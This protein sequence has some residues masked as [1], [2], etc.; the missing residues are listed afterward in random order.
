MRDKTEQCNSL[1]RDA[2]LIAIVCSVLRDASL[3]ANSV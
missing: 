2:A 3:I 1:M